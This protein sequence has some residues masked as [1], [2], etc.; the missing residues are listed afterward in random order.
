MAVIV[1]AGTTTLFRFQQTP[2]S[3]VGS[4]SCFMC[5]IDFARRW[6]A[7]RHSKALLAKDRP[8]EAQ[9]CEACHGPGSLHVAGERGRILRWG[10]LPAAKQTALCLPCHEPKVRANLWEQNPHAV[11]ELSCT[12]CHTVHR[13]MP[14]EP[15]LAKK[16]VELCNPCHQEPL[17]KAV[18]AKTHHLLEVE[19]LTLECGMCHNLHGTEHERSL[20]QPQE[21]LCKT[22]HGQ[23]V[24]QPESHKAAGWLKQHGK[25]FQ[26]AD[27][28]EQCLMC[29]S[30]RGS[31]EACHGG[32]PM[33]HPQGFALKHTEL[34][35]KVGRGCL[36]CHEPTYCELCHEKAP[37]PP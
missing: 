5:H 6:A 25:E 1:L 18:E 37:V 12:F 8:P 3:Y 36:N 15:M 11:L 23:K 17:Q 7:H 21:Q 20:L 22:C 2:P 31:C 16:K 14:E 32:V 9:G 27:Q 28:R 24:P 13:P 35:K 26:K 4:D 10:Q 29:H 19:G 30:Q 34:A 33:P